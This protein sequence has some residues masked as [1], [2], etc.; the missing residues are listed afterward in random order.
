MK[1]VRKFEV[2]IDEPCSKDRALFFEQITEWRSVASTF[3]NE[4]VSFIYS[5]DTLSSSKIMDEESRLVLNILKMNGENESE[6]EELSALFSER[7]NGRLPGEVIGSVYKI[8]RTAYEE[9]RESIKKGKTTLPN[10]SSMPI[11]FVFECLKNISGLEQSNNYSFRLF[12]I[13]MRTEFGRDRSNNFNL[14]TQIISGAI[15][16]PNFSLMIDNRRSKLY[17]L[18]CVDMPKKRVELHEANWLAVSLSSEAPLVVSFRNRVFHVGGNEE[19]MY[20]R[21]QIVESAKRAGQYIK[22]SPGGKGR[23]RKLAAIRR[24]HAK[25]NEYI[26]TKVHNYAKLVVEH[27]VKNR[28][29]TI[30]IVKHDS[31]EYDN[32]ILKSWGYYGLYKKLNYKAALSGISV[33]WG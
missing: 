16:A 21:N 9:S 19:F 2:V 8:V 33:R 4:F 32:L 20:R 12:G 28:C 29:K 11:P 1:V 6:I 3:A 31:S 25:E 7:V 17:M 23:K 27:A 22:F 26:N 15:N 5:V 24:I 30:C 10:Y 13:P 18:A 14:F